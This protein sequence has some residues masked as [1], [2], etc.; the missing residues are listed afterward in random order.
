MT[1]TEPSGVVPRT[2]RWKGILLVAS[3]ALNLLIV[4]IVAAMGVKHGWGP[5][6]AGI[7][8]ATLLRFART[9]PAERKQEIWNVVRP[10]VHTVRPL[11]RDLR[12]A[13][14]HVRSALT[15]D[16]FDENAFRQAH[17]RLLEVEAKVRDAIHP[18]Y[19]KVATLLTAEER[20]EFARWQARAE[21]PWRKRDSTATGTEDDNAENAPSTSH[22]SPVS[23]TQSPRQ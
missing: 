1:D 14:R 4:G 17:D 22:G 7:Q 3:L 16:P 18:I 5:P 15:A 9:L 13:R 2:R 23:A 10:E 12:A 6:P 21:R 19:N 8:Q 20:R 11:W